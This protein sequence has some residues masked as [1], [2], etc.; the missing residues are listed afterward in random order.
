MRVRF[1]FNDNDTL[2][3]IIFVQRWVKVRA[4]H[5]EQRVLKTIFI[6]LLINSIPRKRIWLTLCTTAF[7]AAISK[8]AKAKEL[9][10]FT[11]RLGDDKFTAASTRPFN[12]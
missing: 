3:I 4:D 12:H 8:P 1:S 9:I 10:C 7:S 5:M 6:S 11:L 2:A